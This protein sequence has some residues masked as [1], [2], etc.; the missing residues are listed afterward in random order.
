MV[1]GGNNKRE[2]NSKFLFDKFD[3]MTHLA[4]Q[5]GGSLCCALASI[6]RSE[7]GNLRDL[8]FV[9]PNL[10][11]SYAE[12]RIITIACL[13]FLQKIEITD[14]LYQLAISDIDSGVRKTA[15]WAYVFVNGK[16]VECLY[17]EILADES[18]EQVLSLLKTL[19]A[20]D[21]NPWLL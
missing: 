17:K 5:I 2:D 15:L 18:N 12:H 19:N 10:N 9:L 21:Y 20:N 4:Y 1:F 13:A 7:L 11:S 8:N 16:K 6:A 3:V 14:K